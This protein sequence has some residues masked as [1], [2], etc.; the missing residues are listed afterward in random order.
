MNFIE[1]DFKEARIPSSNLG[2][3]VGGFNY[4][5]IFTPKIGEDVQF[6]SYFSKGLVQF[7]HQ[8]DLFGQFFTDSIHENFTHQ[9]TG[10][11]KWLNELSRFGIP[12]DP[13]TGRYPLATHRSWSHTS[14]ATVEKGPFNISLRY[15]ES[16]GLD[17]INVHMVVCRFVCEQLMCC[18]GSW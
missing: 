9:T 6:N 1:S 2:F 14:F 4:L 17:L 11:K 13:E 16:N 10:R 3:L 15:S 12:V 5:F 7:N 8:L 18:F